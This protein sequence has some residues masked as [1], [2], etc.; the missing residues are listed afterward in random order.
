[1]GLRR[2][3]VI[4][5]AFLLTALPFTTSIADQAIKKDVKETPGFTMGNLIKINSPRS[6]ICLLAFET[7]RW[8]TTVAK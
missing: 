8:V 6:L 2:F 1:M 4:L 7:S 3:S 5:M